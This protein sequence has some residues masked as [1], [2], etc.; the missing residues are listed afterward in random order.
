MVTMTVPAITATPMV[1][2][3]LAAMERFFM[4]AP[5]FLG[6]AIPALPGAFRSSPH[7]GHHEIA[8]HQQPRGDQRVADPA[9]Q[10]GAIQIPR[11]LGAEV[12]AD[13]R[14]RGH[15]GEGQDV[16]VSTRERGEAPGQT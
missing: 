1:M 13:Q 15:Q 12:S 3:S 11:A 10:G 16:D 4:S 9:S 5:L 2:A 6:T 14:Q 8:D 7:E